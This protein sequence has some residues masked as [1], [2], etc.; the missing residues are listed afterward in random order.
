ML[1]Y[2]WKLYKDKEILPKNSLLDDPHNPQ[3]K[4]NIE[5]FNEFKYNTDLCQLKS[6]DYTEV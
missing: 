1:N 3:V 4:F 2:S 6:T 5:K